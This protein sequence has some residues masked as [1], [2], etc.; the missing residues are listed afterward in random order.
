MVKLG[1]QVGAAL[2][3]FAALTSFDAKASEYIPMNSY[4]K[5]VASNF[6]NNVYGMQFKGKRTNG[7]GVTFVAYQFMCDDSH[8]PVHHVIA[9]VKNNKTVGIVPWDIYGQQGQSNGPMHNFTT[10][11][12]VRIIDHTKPG[13][14]CMEGVF[15]IVGTMPD[16]NGNPDHGPMGS[17]EV[18]EGKLLMGPF[19]CN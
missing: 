2:L 5:Q 17:Y 19:D 14:E 6:C 15:N 13:Y 10:F 1:I 8:Y 9:A 7:D 11:E 16:A 4:D 3:S 12:N 18:W